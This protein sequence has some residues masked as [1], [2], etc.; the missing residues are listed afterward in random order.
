MPGSSLTTP[1]VF[2]IFNRPDTT[3]QVFEAIRRARPK[4]LY[5]IA[6][7]PR[8]DRPEEAER[9]AATRAVVEAVDWKCD[10]KKKYS[11]QN[12]GCGERISTGL[13]WVF[14]NEEEAVILEDDC[15]P[16]AGF[17]P[18][19]ES[20]LKRY[21][22]DHRVMHISGTNFTPAERRN[23]DS[24]FFSRYVHI[25]GWA[26][27]GRAWRHYDYTMEAWPRF[28]D[29]GWL[30]DIFRDRNA[31]EFW[32][33]YMDLC[34]DG[35]II[36]STWDY[37]W[38]FSVWQNN[39]LAIT[40]ASNLITNIGLTGIHTDIRNGSPDAVNFN[41]ERDERFTVTNHPEF[42]VADE[43]YDRYHFRKHFYQSVPQR[44]LRRLWRMAGR[45]RNS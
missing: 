22:D 27:W 4:K 38:L 2:I 39:G 36:P 23:H 3:Q 6:D 24:Y 20:L 14:R 21:A 25:W 7:G 42:V 19:C 43:Q 30:N 11:S 41:R 8:K 33:K 32:T 1:V 5:V 44:V 31:A 37:Q 40:P 29:G 35:L 12:M 9:C 26:T 18:Y 17:F 10:V 13:A 15:V 28:R 45:L 16:S 34:H